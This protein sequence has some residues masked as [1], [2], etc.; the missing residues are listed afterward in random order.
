MDNLSP[1]LCRPRPFADESL[2]SYCIRL[3][4]ANGYERMIWLTNWLRSSA[5]TQTRTRFRPTST[6]E[7]DFLE[8]LG[9]VTGVSVMQ[10]YL[11]ILNR[12]LPLFTLLDRQEP[13]IV[14]SSGQKITLCQIRKTMSRWA[15]LESRTAFCPYCIAEEPYHRLNWLLHS[16]FACPKHSCWLLDVCKNCVKPT[17][18]A[19][20][21]NAVCETC[22]ASLSTMSSL[23]LESNLVEIQHHLMSIIEQEELPGDT[24]PPIPRQAFF[25]FLEGLCAA[26][27][28]LG[29]AWEGCCKPDH[30]PQH[31]FPLDFFT[32]LSVIQH[33]ALFASAWQGVDNWP[34]G[35]YTFLDL[36]R[37]RDGVKGNSVCQQL[38]NLYQIWLERNWLHPEMKPIQDSFNNYLSTNFLPSTDLWRLDRFRRTPELRAQMTLVAPKSAARLL[39]ISLPTIR[40]MV[41]DGY[42]RAYYP[43]KGTSGSRYLVYLEDLEVGLRQRSVLITVNQVGIEMGTSGEIVQEWIDAGLINSTGTR[44]VKG[45]SQPGLTRYDVDVFLRQ[46]AQQVHIGMERPDD[47]LT[48]KGVCIRHNKIGV[49]SEK[50]LMRVRDGKLPAY[51]A[52]P[53][54]KPFADLWFL[55]EDVVQ[56]T[57]QIK[58]E[59]NWVTL[60]EVACLLHVSYRRVYHW[61]KHGVLVPEAIFSRSLYFNR[62]DIIAFQKCK[63]TSRQV[64]DWLQTSTGALSVWIRAGYLPV[65]AGSNCEDS[66]GYFFDRDVIAEWHATYITTSELRH[67]LGQEEF[68]NFRLLVKRGFIIPVTPPGMM[69]R[70]YHR[71]DL[72]RFQT[73]LVQKL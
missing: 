72:E 48:L 51:H 29:W 21:V 25:R 49:T 66:K 69:S 59:N 47:A 12:Y 19:S 52:H 4:A 32:N 41:R 17:S 37:Q 56:L 34:Q 67:K 8:N 13:E 15:R 63:M 26:T 18:V 1:L 11:M 57:E 55:R 62:E 68:R 30:V 50:L 22:G 38:G 10:L 54:L 64:A 14:L 65:I 43:E 33:G 2:L 24:L 53:E 5:K 3:Q 45:K 39:D 71:A 60:R 20:V 58:Q 16:V 73:G 6:N 31:A 46:L 35:F 27:Q 7:V 23:P 28:R 40:R 70:F 36:Y 61:V 9:V 42:V 44:M